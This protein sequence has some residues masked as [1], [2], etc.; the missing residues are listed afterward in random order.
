MMVLM[1][2]R[3]DKGGERRRE[4]EE[5]GDGLTRLEGGENDIKVDLKNKQRNNI[6]IKRLIAW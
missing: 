1:S 2:F 3:K 6:D 5:R 4:E